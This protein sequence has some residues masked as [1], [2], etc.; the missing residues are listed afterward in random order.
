MRMLSPLECA[1]SQIADEEPFAR[2]GLDSAIAV[3]L[4]GELGAWLQLD[5]DPTIFWEFSHPLALAEHL[6]GVL[7][8]RNLAGAPVE[9][10]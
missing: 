5:L 9:H 1:P 4:T 2:F 10:A 7:A 3:T 8:A 6:A